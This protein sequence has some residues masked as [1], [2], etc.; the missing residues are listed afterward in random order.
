MKKRQNGYTLIEIMVAMGLAAMLM[1][2][3][4]KIFLST[5][6]L[7]VLSKGLADVQ[8]S[9][10]FALELMS[11]DVRNADYW[12]CLRSTMLITDQLNKNDTDYQ[13]MMSIDQTTNGIE[14]IENHQS[15]T[16]GSN[17]IPVV[18]SSD[19]LHIRTGEIPDVFVMEEGMTANAPSSAIIATAGMGLE[20][21]DVLLISNCS[22]GDLFVNTTPFDPANPTNII[23][24]A[25][26][27]VN[28]KPDNASPALSTSYGQD[29]LILLPKFSRYFI[30]QHAS[31]TNAD[32]TPVTSLYRIIN[33]ETPEEL[34]RHVTDMQITYGWDYS[35]DGSVDHYGNATGVE[36][37]LLLDEYLEEKDPYYLK[38]TTILSD[39]SDIEQKKLRWDMVVSAKISLTIRSHER[40]NG[41]TPYLTRVYTKTSN[42]RNR[43]L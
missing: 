3:I 26:T 35:Q 8:S 17:F 12:G 32:N 36:N 23:A 22:N 10:R 13:P 38:G 40:T 20:A 7:A 2:G 19:S 18:D 41:S 28:N 14:G 5:K 29:A 15:D 43:S 9:G 16:L 27:N 31:D 37:I 39:Y 11:K 42:I 30:G 33:G 34:I 24:H 25:V 4:S 1:L 6:D 21:G